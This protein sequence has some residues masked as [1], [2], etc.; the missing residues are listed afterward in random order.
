MRFK[1]EEKIK[2][3][4]ISDHPLSPSGVG[5][6]T[7]YMIESILATGKFKV[8]CLG[9][10]VKHQNYEPILVE[11]YDDNWMIIPVDGYGTQD[12]VRSMLANHKP[13]ILW[14]MTD[15]RFYEWLWGMEN[16]IRSNVPMVY[17]H[18]WDNYPLPDFNKKY[19]D[20]ND[21]I[22]SISKLTDDVVRKVAPDIDCRYLPHAVDNKVFKPFYSPKVREVREKLTDGKEKFLVFWNNRNARRKQSG[23]LIFWF[24]DFLDK[25]GHDKATLVMHTDP[26][27]PNGQDLQAILEK[28]G[29][30]NGEVI[31]SVQKVSPEDMAILYNACD[32]VINISDA[33]GFGLST[34]EAMSCGKPIIVNKTGGLSSQMSE[35]FEAGFFIEPASKA[36]IGSQNVPYIYEDRLASEDVVSALE[37][38]FILWTKDEVAYKEM[39]RAA[40]KN[41]KKNFNFDELK[42]KWAEIM[43]DVHEKYGSWENRKNYKH[44]KLYEF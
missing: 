40:L 38:M 2:V 18:V 24:K 19:Y 36:V 13:D 4:V 16:E 8:L 23:S 39:C 31:I 33:E 43:L 11:G 6:Q 26:N 42:E 29:L 27:D 17:Y 5:I 14:F 21:V 12:M 25:V 9:G 7:K 35:E 1:V 37:D 44:Y 10:A 22:V 28:L 30:V 3:M 41:V 32:C 34:L 20:S 15:P